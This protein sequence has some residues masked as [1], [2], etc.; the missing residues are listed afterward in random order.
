MRGWVYFI[1]T[2]TPKGEAV[3]IGFTSGKPERR[4]C[5]LQTGSPT[6]LELAAFIKGTPSLERKMHRE[7]AH[8]RLRGEWFD[9]DDSD[10]FYAFVNACDWTG[11]Y[12]RGEV[13]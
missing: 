4:L 11:R 2:E 8:A 10:V 6:K 7:F 9:L 3:K 12:E 5:G 1:I 13:R